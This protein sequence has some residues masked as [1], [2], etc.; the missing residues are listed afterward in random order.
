VHAGVRPPTTLGVLRVPYS[1]LPGSIRSGE[2]ARLKST[3]AIRPD[4][5]SSGRTT[6]LVVPG[7]VVDSRTTSISGRRWRDT[8]RVA[9]ITAV[10]SGPWSEDSGVGTQMTATAAV[11]RSASSA[12]A[13]KPAARIAATS[14][15]EMSS[16]CE[17][18]A[19]RAATTPGSTSKPST[20][21]PARAASR[22]RGRPT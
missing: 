3:P 21:S 5:S 4:S 15:P 12:V 14:A 1:S 22:A 13:R 17:R 8:A 10:R 19:F 9:A 7:Y 6:S 16:T 20:L 2:K 11:R 18:P